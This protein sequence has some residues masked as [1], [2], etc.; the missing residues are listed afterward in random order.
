MSK[1]G[2]P[3]PRVVVSLA[4][5]KKIECFVRLASGEINGLGKITQT[6]NLLITDV[7]TLPENVDLWSADYTEAYNDFLTDFVANGG[8]PAELRFQWHSHG[9]ITTFFS[10][11]DSETIRNS[12]A[13][14][15]LSLVIN[16]KRDYLC[17]LDIFRPFRLSFAV[18]LLVA[19]PISLWPA[20]TIEKDVLEACKREMAQNVKGIDYLSRLTDKT[21]SRFLKKDDVPRSQIL[22]PYEFLVFAEEGKKQ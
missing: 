13:D 4:A 11:E 15:R 8:D 5:I 10:E 20:I 22:V 21:L 1:T 19:L 3:T 9:D 16:K 6:E 18:P 2:V 17:Q 7:F 14:W 12:L